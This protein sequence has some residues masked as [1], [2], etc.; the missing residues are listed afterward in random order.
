VSARTALA[1]LAA[2]WV[3]AGALGSAQDLGETV[4]GEV[5][6]VA[7]R[8]TPARITVRLESGVEVDVTLSPRVRVTFKPGVWRFDERP[9]ASD[10]QP[11]MIVQF[12]WDPRRVDRVLVL[13]AP[14]GARPGGG[15]V[16]PAA[17]SWGGIKGTATYEAGHELR[18]VVVAVDA[19]AGTLSAR[20]DGRVET[21]LGAP[22]DLRD[23]AR[24][25][26]VVLTTGDAGR[27]VGVR[28][29]RR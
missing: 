24:G 20:V 4:R 13:S 15:L 1:G 8:D 28:R 26:R 5:T 19:A 6:A 3:A 25:D 21:F 16:E 29:E 11:A 12:R 23:L 10:L 7:L 18:A 22:D 17:A 2:A 14:E 9:A 27:V